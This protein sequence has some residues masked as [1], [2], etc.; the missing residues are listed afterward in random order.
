MSQRKFTKRQ[1]DIYKERHEQLIIGKS[2][3]GKRPE[4]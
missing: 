4:G 3:C 1:E 2:I